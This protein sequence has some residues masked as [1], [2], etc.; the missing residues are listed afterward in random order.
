MIRNILRSL[1][2]S[3]IRWGL[4]VP[5][6]RSFQKLR[7]LHEIKA[8]VES[9][10]VD[11]I[12]DVGANEGSFSESMR[13]IGFNGLIHAFEPIP[14]ECRKMAERL[15]GDMMLQIHEV[16]LGSESK[17]QDFNIN[18]VHGTS[19]LSSFLNPAPNLQE[20]F[21]PFTEIGTSEVRPVKVVRADDILKNIV[22]DGRQMRV[23][24]KVDTQ[25]YESEVLIGF[26]DKIS[27]VVALFMELSVVPIYEGMTC[28]TDMIAHLEDL[29][30]SLVDLF[31][32]NR[33]QWGGVLEYNCLMVRDDL[34]KEVVKLNR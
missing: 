26:G 22:T 1:G 32:E 10:K 29:G 15:G 33:T 19:T 16:A 31:V 25:G 24:L 4:P 28:Y 7:E 9:L 21:F 5:E 14:Q 27:E 8:V 13:R 6:V 34:T 12:F 17:T 11:C 18:L 3:A 30:F 20:S 2:F 23:F